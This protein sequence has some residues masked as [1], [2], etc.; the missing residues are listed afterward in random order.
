MTVPFVESLRDLNPPFEILDMK[1]G[2]TIKLRC[3]KWELGKTT[4][5]NRTTGETKVVQVL[6]VHVCKEYKNSYPF[7]WDITAK[8][9]IAQLLPILQRL[10]FSR[11]V[12]T[13]TKLGE[14]PI[15]RFTVD[16]QPAPTEEKCEAPKWPP[17]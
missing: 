10:D 2:E 9:L 13:I 15:A 4:I 14:K 11:F 12:I 16:V 5:V 3:Y 1:D 7:Y 6:R 17:V 8:R